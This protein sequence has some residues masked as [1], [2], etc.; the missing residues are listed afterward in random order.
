LI[1]RLNPGTYVSNGRVL[2]VQSYEYASSITIEG[3][4]QTIDCNG[5]QFAQ[6]Q[7]ATLTINNLTVT[8]G[9]GQYL[10]NVHDGGA[11][12]YFNHAN[13]SNNHM[14]RHII[15]DNNAYVNIANSYFGYNTGDNGTVAQLT[16]TCSGDISNSIFDNNVAEDIA[17]VFYIHT[18]SQDGI[19][20]HNNIIINN[21]ADRGGVFAFETCQNVH[22]YEN[23]IEYNS[24]TH[25]GAIVDVTTGGMNAILENNTIKYNYLPDNEDRGLDE[26][27]LF[28][29]NG[30]SL[31]LIGNDISE[32]IGYGSSCL[33]N[34][35]GHFYL[36][37][38]TISKNHLE[39]SSLIYMPTATG[40]DHSLLMEG[41]VLES[42]EIQVTGDYHPWIINMNPLTSN[43]FNYI[44]VRNNTFDNNTV[45]PMNGERY[46]DIL[47][48]DITGYNNGQEIS[49]NIYSNNAL[50]ITGWSTNKRS[51]STH[52]IIN[53]TVTAREIYNTTVT[54]GT[55]RVT[56]QSGN[57]IGDFPVVNGTCNISIPLEDIAPLTI[58]D[59]DVSYISDYKHYQY[60][61]N[62]TLSVNAKPKIVRE[63]HTVRIY[64]TYESFENGLR[65]QITGGDPTITE[66]VTVYRADGGLVARYIKLDNQG[67]ATV[68]I[69]ATMQEVLNH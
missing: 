44:Y 30:G 39:G 19:N 34:I 46:E 20:I 21:S 67:T 16:G 17:G 4:G 7:A 27:C 45:I 54:N 28:F 33:F 31:T 40:G 22:I 48:K 56:D 58:N 49:G 55:I 11:R 69:P 37:N 52:A 42:N 2:N 12:L 1:I 26:G 68:T 51:N 15:R 14:T 6:I 8:N 43:W 66:R 65:L 64:G 5:N 36:Y 29:A 47:I 23:I 63:G 53:V 13:I 35:H 18:S 59:L 9:G 57:V 38:N 50:N 62:S 24:A 3:N 60:Y 61:A 41:N 25:R 32:N 10:F